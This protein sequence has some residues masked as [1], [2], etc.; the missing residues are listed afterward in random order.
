MRSPEDHSKERSP[1][2]CL[3]GVYTLPGLEF[4]PY[5]LCLLSSLFCMVFSL[6]EKNQ[7]SGLLPFWFL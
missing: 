4:S 7:L 6:A 2:N 1:E 3:T 5:H